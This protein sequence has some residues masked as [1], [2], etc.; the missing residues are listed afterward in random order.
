MLAKCSEEQNNFPSVFEGFGCLRSTLLVSQLGFQVR[1]F[2]LIVTLPNVSATV[3]VLVTM[4]MH[5]YQ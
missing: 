5:M 2:N 4:I 1:Q 3:S